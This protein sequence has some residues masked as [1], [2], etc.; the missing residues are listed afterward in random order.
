M[1]QPDTKQKGN[2][3]NSLTHSKSKGVWIV[4]GGLLIVLAIL[5]LAPKSSKPS[6][7]KLTPPNAAPNAETATSSEVQ[8][9]E[10]METTALPAAETEESAAQ[11]FLRR[12]DEATNPRNIAA[13]N[14]ATKENLEEIKA[15][16]NA[17]VLAETGV[18]LNLENSLTLEER[19]QRKLQMSR[20]EW[21]EHQRK[22]DRS[23][24][25][26]MLM[27]VKMF[28]AMRP[29]VPES[30]KDAFEEKLNLMREDM[31]ESQ[32]QWEELR[33]RGKRLDEE[34]TSWMTPTQK[35]QLAQE[36]EQRR[37]AHLKEAIEILRQ[38]GKPPWEEAAEAIRA[39]KT[40]KLPLAPPSAP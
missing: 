35:E 11:A 25:A 34:L 4:G 16:I 23:G 38:G 28:E 15:R 2:S 39:G 8:S 10:T 26:M 24:E 31:K 32:R 9:R 27:L 6:T 33:A 22:Q 40:P 17:E 1:V 19:L 36:E 14:T 13:R 21:E 20:E 37:K 7:A 12:V 29:H 3:M 18:D 30:G 5:W